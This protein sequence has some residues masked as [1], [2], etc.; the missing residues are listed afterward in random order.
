MGH[1]DTQTSSRGPPQ[2]GSLRLCIHQRD[3]M[4]GR[5]I[6]DNIIESI[7]SSRKS[8]L[9]VSNAFASSQWCYF[10]MTMA[11]TKLFQSDMD[12]M[13]VVLM[14]EIAECNLN[15]R[16]RLQL[17]RQTYIEW[18]ESEIGQQLFWSRLKQALSKPADSLVNQPI[19]AEQFYEHAMPNSADTAIKV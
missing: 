12:N 9:I 17:E 4:V 11:Q 15:P 3:W 16:L 6:A 5:D 10:E 19:N 18:S 14:E 1:P 13:I 2:G 8:L 7:Q